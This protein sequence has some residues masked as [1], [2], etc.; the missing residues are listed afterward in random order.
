MALWACLVAA[1]FCAVVVVQLFRRHSDD[2][3]VVWNSHDHED[4]IHHEEFSWRD[5]TNRAPSGAALKR[6]YRRLARD[7]HPDQ[8]GTDEQFKALT[9]AHSQ[10]QS[11]L[12]YNLRAAL[13]R[14]SGVDGADD[15]GGEHN[16][17]DFRVALVPTAD[18]GNRIRLEID[19]TTSA[20]R[21]Y[22]RLGLL[23]K[24]DSA[25]EYNGDGRGYD[26]CCKFLNGSKC[27]FKPYKDL[28]AQHT[29]H[30]DVAW[31]STYAAH[32]CPLQPGRFYTGVVEKPL[33]VESEGPWA[34][35]LDLFDADSQSELA[36]AVATF[37]IDGGVMR[38]LR[39]DSPSVDP[40]SPQ[41]AE[42]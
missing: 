40:S 30:T 39:N 29:A 2:A 41:R 4:A 24:G 27:E 17:R 1:G 25:I 37:R 34:A 38:P 3:H 42:G 26:M 32:D 8:G 23:A 11:P 18:Q 28:V 15:A 14:P 19:F 33:H 20:R 7:A 13:A 21:G 10:L 16:I 12:Q 36:C 35:V 22:Y 31:D 5:C 6:A 9:S